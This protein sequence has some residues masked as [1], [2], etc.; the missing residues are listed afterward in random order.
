MLKRAAA[1]LLLVVWVSLSTGAAWV[2]HV[3]SEADE[4]PTGH[5]S[6]HKEH[7]PHTHEEHSVLVPRRPVRVVRRT[8]RREVEA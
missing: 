3:P 4:A 1:A 7:D 6:A 8:E 5:A 2:P